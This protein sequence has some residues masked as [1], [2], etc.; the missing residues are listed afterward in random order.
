VVNANYT[1]L[2]DTF[3][4][5]NAPP[6]IDYPTVINNFK[7]KR[8]DRQSDRYAKLTAEQVSS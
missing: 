6:K 3:G 4:E 1:L 8:G 5:D 2:Q 7:P